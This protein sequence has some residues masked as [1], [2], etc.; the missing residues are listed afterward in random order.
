MNTNAWTALADAVDVGDNVTVILKSGDHLNG[1]VKMIAP[2]AGF[3]LLDDWTI[4]SRAVI[5]WKLSSA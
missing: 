3:V 1:R 4:D 2:A 5:A